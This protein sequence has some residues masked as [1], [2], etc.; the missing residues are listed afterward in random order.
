MPRMGEPRV[1]AGMTAHLTLRES[2]RTYDANIILVA[3]AAD[4][5]TRLVQV[6][7]TVDDKDHKYWLRPGAF[8]DVSIPV[9]DARQAAVVPEI[10]IRA[11]ERGFLAYV[12]QGTTAKERPL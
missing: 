6:T 9:G 5:T 12:I 4:P 3:A 10:A 11:T 1:K 2:A 8:C 7:A